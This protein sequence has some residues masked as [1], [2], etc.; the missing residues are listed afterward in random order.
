MKRAISKLID[1]AALF[2]VVMIC[3]AQSTFGKDRRK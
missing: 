3:I 1:Q 2:I